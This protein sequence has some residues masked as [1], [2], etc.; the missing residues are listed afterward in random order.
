MKKIFNL[1]VIFLAFVGLFFGVYF[2]VFVLSWHLALK[3]TLAGIFALV[4]GLCFSNINF[5]KFRK[6]AILVVLVSLLVGFSYSAAK[7]FFYNRSQVDENFFVSGKVT[8]K[9]KTYDECQIVTLKDVSDNKSKL[10]GEMSL[11]VYCSDGQALCAGDE[12]SF[13]AVVKSY[14]IKKA[15]IINASIEKTGVKYFASVNFDDI[16]VQH[17]STSFFENIRIS[18]RQKILENT[19]DEQMGNLIYSVIFG[20]KTYLSN[21]I[22]NV[23]SAS[24]TAHLLAVSGLHVGFI[25]LLIL[26]ILNLCKLKKLVKFILICIFLVGYNVLCGFSPSIVRA[27]IMTVFLLLAYLFGEKYDSLTALG[28]AGILIL[29]VKPLMAFDIGF[30]L[31]FGSVFGIICFGSKIT[32]YFEKIKIPKLIAEGMA[33]CIASTIGSFAFAAIYF[34]KLAYIGIIS[35][36]LVIPIFGV[37][38][39]LT[40]LIFLVSLLVPSAAS[41]Y[42]ISEIG[43]IIICKICVIFGKVASLKLTR[44]SLLILMLYPAFM[45]ISDFALISEKFKKH[46]T[47]AFVAVFSLIFAA[48]LIPQKVSQTTFA[49]LET[50]A[51]VLIDE[52]DNV[53]LVTRNFNEYEIK[54]SMDYLYQNNLD[55]NLAGIV[56]TD[57]ASDLKDVYNFAKSSAQKIYINTNN[58]VD[59]K[60][61]SEINNIEVVSSGDE[62]KI[63]GFDVMFYDQN[64]NGRTCAATVYADGFCILF[65]N[66]ISNAEAEFLN[67]VFE[68]NDVSICVCNRFENNYNKLNFNI[69]KFVASKTSVELKKDVEL[70]N[71]HISIIYG[72]KQ[73]QVE[74]KDEICWS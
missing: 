62:I 49:K 46:L 37:V 2:S 45:F 13:E 55:E 9:I 59:E 19:K 10:S 72:L 32:S 30:Q 56:V 70:T 71:E 23:F 41:L 12:I 35:N 6:V 38:F 21:D 42:V 29:M 17:A 47:V 74:E 50:N 26:F 36:I 65:L 64:F 16:D 4:F 53:L 25:V 60:V 18:S 67:L 51:S 63:C 40:F 52:N 5:F 34:H 68:D 1:R 48:S 57:K 44:I 58:V 61:L 39:S 54:K 15:G 69:Q 43:F 27:S 66:S 33:I 3:I 24:G 31:S 11:T 73:K 20:D 7:I 28:L 8:D 14:E 22:Y